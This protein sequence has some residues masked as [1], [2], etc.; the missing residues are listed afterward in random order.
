M[1]LISCF[2][3]EKIQGYLENAKNLHSSVFNVAGSFISVELSSDVAGVGSSDFMAPMPRLLTS[4]LNVSS[5][6]QEVKFR[7]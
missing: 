4:W 1:D 7:E 5:M 6:A 3:I 2:T